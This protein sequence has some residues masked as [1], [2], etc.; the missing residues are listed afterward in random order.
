LGCFIS[1]SVVGHPKS[2]QTE[3]EQG[4]GTRAYLHFKW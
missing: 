4:P 3:E 1:R 2:V